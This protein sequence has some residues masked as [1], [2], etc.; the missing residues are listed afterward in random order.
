[1]VSQISACLVRSAPS[2]PQRRELLPSYPRGDS[3][4]GT[5]IPLSVEHQSVAPCRINNEITPGSGRG[6]SLDVLLTAA[7]ILRTRPNTALSR[8]RFLLSHPDELETIARESYWHRNGFAR[9]KIVERHGVC[10]RLHVWPAG[11][12][13]VGDIDPHGHRW[14][15]ASW[16]AVGQ[17]ITETYFTK[18]DEADSEGSRYVRLDYGRET[19]SGYLSQQGP[20]WL[21]RSGWRWRAV[22]EVYGCPLGVLHTVAPQGDD[23]VATVMMQ[24]PV[25]A[26]AAEVFRADDQPSESSAA[27]ERPITAAELRHLFGA[28]EAAIGATERR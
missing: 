17:G 23:L 5:S 20:A 8:L 1:M 3:R 14:E 22:G 18:T 4:N 12:N 25:I 19:G 13:R 16:V 2:T 15:F 24:G 9:V 26:R 27:P 11:E 21:R 28:V 7:A 10:V 6:A